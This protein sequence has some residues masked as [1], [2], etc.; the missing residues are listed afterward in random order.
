[1]GKFDLAHD[2]H[3]ESAVNTLKELIEDEHFTDVTLVCNDKPIR[4]H[5]AILSVYSSVLKDIIISMKQPNPV[6]YMRGVTYE[7]MEYLVK[8]IYLGR[9]KISQNVFPSFMNLANDL[10]I[11]SLSS[12]FESLNSIIKSD[13]KESS[14][15]SADK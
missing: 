6:I 5:K 9:V 4:V 11:V 15:I 8:F 10:K 1:M 13:E 2:Q 14:G 3:E 12:S 7:E